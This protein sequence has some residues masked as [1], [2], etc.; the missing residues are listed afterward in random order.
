MDEKRKV[1]TD[2]DIN[3]VPGNIFVLERVNIWTTDEK[4]KVQTDL[5]KAQT[6]LDVHFVPGNILEDHV[7]RPLHVQDEEVHCGIAK[8]QKQAVQGKALDLQNK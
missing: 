6:D 2:L 5:G 7:L 4:R 8:G 1:Q 3:F